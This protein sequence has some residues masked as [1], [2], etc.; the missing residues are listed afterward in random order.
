MLWIV[1]ITSLIDAILVIPALILSS[2]ESRKE[3]EELK[4]IHK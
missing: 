1:F 4:N 2:R 3:E